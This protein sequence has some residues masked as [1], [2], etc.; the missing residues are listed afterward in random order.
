MLRSDEIRKPG[1]TWCAVTKEHARTD[2]WDRIDF[3][4]AGKA[5]PN[6]QHAHGTEWRVVK[7]VVIGESGEEAEEVISPWPSDHRAVLAELRLT[8]KLDRL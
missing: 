6:T 4:F 1:F 7:S 2:H 5:H 3:V 8:H